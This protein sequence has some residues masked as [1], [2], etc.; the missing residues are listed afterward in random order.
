[1]HITPGILTDSFTTLQQEVDMVRVSPLVD[2]IHIDIIDGIFAD[3]LTVTPLDLTVAEFEPTK[4][5]FHVL[6][7]EPMDIVYECETVQEYLPIERIIGQVEKM[8]HQSDFIHEV[9][10]HNWEPGLALDLFTPLDAIDDD[11]WGQFHHL[12]L[13][14]VEAGFSDQTFHRSVLQKIKEVRERFPNPKQM[15]IIIDGGIKIFNIRE[16]LE[17]G[18]SEVTATSAFWDSQDP[19]LVLEEF[20]RVVSDVRHT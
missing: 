5:E 4:I 19:L 3:N 13:M 10:S 20:H 14:S 1:M 16:V 9:K 8:S 15:N 6:T 7:E 11:V 18:A 17:A 2:R 12:L